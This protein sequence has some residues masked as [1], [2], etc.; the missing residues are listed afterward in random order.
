MPHYPN[1]PQIIYDDL[2]PLYEV[3][4]GVMRKHDGVSRDRLNWGSL[5]LFI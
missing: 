1:S 2:S 4:R 3:E 5:L